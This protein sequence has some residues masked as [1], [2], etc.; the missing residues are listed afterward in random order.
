MKNRVI[1]SV[2]AAALAA[3]LFCGVLPFS[4][5]A[6]TEME[7]PKNCKDD[8][9]ETAIL[10]EF[11]DTDALREYL[12][13]QFKSCPG[14]V[15]ISD[16]KIPSD[17]LDALRVFIWREIPECFHVHA[18]GSYY[19]NPIPALNVNYTMS[20]E[21]YAE[22]LSLC[23]EEAARLVDGIAGNDGLS[24][25]EKALLLHDRLALHNEYDY[26]FADDSATMYAALV[27]RNSVCEGYARAYSYLLRLCG[28]ECTSCVSYAL[29]HSWNLV[30]IDGQFYH[31]DVTWDDP[32][33][34][35]GERGIVGYVGHD[36]FL[37][38]NDGI[39]S[40]KHTAS[41]YYAPATDTKYDNYF[42]QNTNAAF[43]LVGDDIYYIDG[44]QQKVMRLNDDG[45]TG[46]PLYSVEAKWSAGG[47]YYWKGNF[48][49]LYGALNNLFFS[50]NKKVYLYD[51]TEDKAEV[52]LEPALAA[53]ESIYGL[54]YEDGCIIC[55]INDCPGN[56]VTNLRQIR[57]P[58]SLTYTVTFKDYDGSV[59]SSAEYAA[60]TEVTVPD[61]PERQANETYTYS[62]SGWDKP[63]TE[64]TEN[65]EYTATYSAEYIDYTV[66][67][68]DC[69]GGVLSE[70]TYHYGDAVT[71]PAVPDVPANE[72]YTYAF[73]GWDKEVTTV[74]G[75]AEY[76]PVY[77]AT[78]IEYGVTFKDYDNSVISSASY[79]YGDTVDVPADPQRP[80]DETFTYAFDGWD[81]PVTDVEGDA[82]YTAT[83]T[84]EYREYTV[85]F[86]DWDGVVLSELT[87]RYGDEVDAPNDPERAPDGEI[88][89]VFTGWDKEIKACTGDETYTATYKKDGAAR[90]VSGKITANKAV[91]IALSDADG[92]IISQETA[93]N[94]EFD[95]ELADGAEYITISADGYIPMIYKLESYGETEINA[96]LKLAGDVNADR[97]VNNKDV[98]VL[99]RYVS[100]VSVRVDADCADTNGDGSINNKDVTVLFRFVSS[101]DAELKV[102]PIIMY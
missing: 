39:K 64:V 38:S 72:T 80:A 88:T 61:I 42:W 73:D 69:N 4:S 102:T 28:I 79:H 94:G 85:R 84:S 67:F 9:S 14:R 35:P 57:V 33:W 49:K 45:V 10:S 32:S 47:A 16:F 65:A 37:R 7:Y 56:D 24:D 8:G 70:Q 40:T 77:T 15:D 1:K 76:H 63:V 3:C 96:A 19:G 30:K 83:Y 78:Y 13:E 53:G 5:F 62:F 41:D 81:K 87:Y 36:N 44:S 75:D 21:E 22:K 89:Y 43:Q 101:P 68:Y 99:F 17:Q 26:T 6:V 29:N 31:V 90:T 74:E 46:T 18:M 98:T 52:V 54:S 66:I 25:V 100:G 51:L 58:Y 2:I 91:K 71:A 23:E 55:D 92:N 86:V 97:A 60:G 93:E 27:K 50:N 20:P 12:K 95:F 59:I 34:M 11:I 82:E 48:A